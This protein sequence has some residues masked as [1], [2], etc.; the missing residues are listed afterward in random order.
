MSKSDRSQTTQPD[1]ERI[2]RETS[3]SVDPARQD[4]AVDD[5]AQ[6]EDREL[7]EEDRLQMFQMQLFNEVLP[8]LPRIP[9]YH[10]CWLTTANPRDTIQARMR[11]GYVPIKPEEVP[12]FEYASLKTGEYAG[13]IGVNEMLAFKIPLTLYQRF[14][15]EAHH[16]APLREAEKLTVRVDQLREGAQAKGGNVVE[17]D[18]M[19]AIRSE[20]HARTPTFSE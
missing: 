12:G 10:T 8:D 9:G 18:G 5:R 14:M 16:D 15:K 17:Y 6:S 3:R 19:Q 13:M 1:D 20:R 2:V 7:T 4:R 11:L